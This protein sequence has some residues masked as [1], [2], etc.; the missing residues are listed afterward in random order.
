MPGPAH[1]HRRRR[2]TRRSAVCWC[3]RRRQSCVEMPPVV[4]QVHALQRGRSEAGAHVRGTISLLPPE[5]AVL[6]RRQKRTAMALP[7]ATLRPARIVTQISSTATVPHLS[8]A[9]GGLLSHSQ[10][11]RGMRWQKCDA[12]LWLRCAR[13]TRLPARRC[14]AVRPIEGVQ[15]RPKRYHVVGGDHGWSLAAINEQRSLPGRWRWHAVAMAKVTAC[16]FLFLSVSQNSLCDSA[17]WR[18]RARVR[19]R[20]RAC[21]HTSPASRVRPLVRPHSHRSRVPTRSRRHQRR[22]GAGLARAVWR[23]RENA[24]R[25]NAQKTQCTRE[26]ISNRI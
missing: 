22:N 21:V 6:R 16:P 14:D 23:A 2:L 15:I 24:Q 17:S 20:A 5:R 4:R 3:G 12:I 1:D 26:C 9:S 8:R 11:A 18:A 19:A 25:A 10:H 13:A 7:I